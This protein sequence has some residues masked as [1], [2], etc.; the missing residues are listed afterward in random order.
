M[1]YAKKNNKKNMKKVNNKGNR[2]KAFK[3]ANKKRFAI[4][5][6]PF[7]EMKSI[8]HSEL[9]QKMGGTGLNI[10]DHIRDPRILDHMAT[11][12]I[13]PSSNNIPFISRMFPIW[14]YMNPVNGT[15]DNEMIGRSLT[16]KYL[17]ARVHFEFPVNAQLKNP[18]YYIIHG[19]ITKP[20]CLSDFTSP[21]KTAYTRSDLLNH[22]AAQVVD[23]F[24]NDADDEFLDFKEKQNKNYKILGYRRI[25]PKANENQI[26]PAA[27]LTATSIVPQTFGQPSDQNHTFKWPLNN[28][29]LRYTTG[30]T[31]APVSTPFLYT[32]DGDYVPFMLYYCPDTDKIPQVTSGSPPITTYPDNQCPKIAYE[33]KFW[34]TDS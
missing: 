14:S 6:A 33:N 19:W 13:T 28:R 26:D 10:V 34:F 29:K 31:V 17:T 30:Q 12:T 5:R 16:A 23:D 3:P 4:K 32:N 15:A 2:K 21:V 11:S 18:R 22:I 20:H 25:K 8:S 27:Y 1:V 9:W 24:N 7:T